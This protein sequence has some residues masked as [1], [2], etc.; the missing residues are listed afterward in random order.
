MAR[1]RRHE[2]GD[3]LRGVE[4][5][6]AL[7]HRL[8]A[9]PV[10]DLARAAR[11]LNVSRSTAYRVLRSLE[12]GGL[13]VYDRERR[14]YHLSLAIARLGQVALSRIDL[15]TVARP[16][17]HRLAEATG[18]S[19]FLLVVEGRSA[20]VI[21]TLASEAP[22]KLT[23][24]V[25]TPWPLHAGA[26]NK[27]LLAHLPPERIDEILAG[28]LPRVTP[29]TT[30]DPR[31]LRGELERIR[32]RGYAYS[33]GELTPGVVGIA[34]PILCAGQL[35]GA[36]AVAGPSARLPAARV[37]GIVKQ[38]RTAADA[39]VQQLVGTGAKAPRG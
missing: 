35:M 9:D 30:T 7:L 14:A 24:P 18:E 34:V 29:R 27:V 17:L 39:I 26:S 2:P 15:R 19:V 8:T 6:V 4:R 32:R 10:L 20:V 12:A 25:G 28:P 36:L 11:H 38:L 3:V 37:P 5:A 22:L 23:Y 33:N 21:D 1:P 31:R 13:L 16:S